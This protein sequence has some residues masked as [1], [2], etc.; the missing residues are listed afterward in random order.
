MLHVYRLPGDIDPPRLARGAA[1]IIDI[2]RASTT[3]LHALAAGAN[4]IAPCLEVEEALALAAAMPR[5]SYVLGGERGGVLIPGFDLG[6]T[7]T[8]Y[9]PE[10]VGGKTVIFTTTNGTRTML[11]ATHARRVLI[12]AFNNASAVLREIEREDQIHL[13]CAGSN[14]RVTI[15]DVL[16]AGMLAARLTADCSRPLNAAAEEARQTW[17]DAIPSPYALGQSPPV[18]LLASELG[19]GLAGQK[20]AQ[21]G[22]AADVHTAARIDRFDLVAEF[23]AA[24]RRVRGQ[25]GGRPFG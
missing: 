1:V 21:L 20:L 25:A 4:E 3:M 17:L 9:T 7:P 10:R 2:L 18:E 24:S 22:L 23:H 14:D 8:D 16:F 15:D 6:N 11:R 13:L 19:R 12:G 5:E